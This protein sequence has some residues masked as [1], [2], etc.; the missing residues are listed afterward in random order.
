MSEENTRTTW[1]AEY[2]IEVLNKFTSWKSDEF[3]KYSKETG[4]AV[5]N[6]RNWA[7]K[8]GN[9]NLGLLPTKTRSSSSVPVKSKVTITTEL[10]AELQKELDEQKSNEAAFDQAI[11]SFNRTI[12]MFTRMRDQKIQKRENLQNELRSKLGL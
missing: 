10:L 4:V 11:E 5:Q 1:N 12:A 3:K 2:K 6:L 7:K 8:I 9:A